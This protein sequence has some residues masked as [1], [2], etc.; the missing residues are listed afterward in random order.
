MFYKRIEPFLNRSEFISKFDTECVELPTKSVIN[1]LNQSAKSLLLARALEITCKNIIM[2][3]SDDKTAEEFT[4]DVDLL[5]GTER[6]FYLPDFEVLPYEERSPHYVI[7]AQRI[8]AL[9]RAVTGEPAVFNLSLRSFLR[10]IVHPDIFGEH[11]INLK[12]GEEY[13]PQL[14][15]SNLVGMGYENEYQ[16]SKVGDVARRGGIIDVFSPSTSKPVRI[17]FFGD[18]IESIRIFSISS[19]RSTGEELKSIVLLPSRE[20]SLHDIDTDEKM[21]E[22]IHKDGFYEGIESDVSLLLP[23]TGTFLDFFQQN[24]CLIF[25]DNFQYFNNYIREI[26]EETTSLYQKAALKNKKRSFVHP[27]ELFKNKRYINKI[28]RKYDHFYLSSG[29]QEIKNSLSSYEAPLL[30]QNNLHGKLED[31]EAE[32]DRRISENYRIIIQSDNSSQSKRMRDLLPQLEEQLDF[33]IGVFQKGFLLTD[34][35]IA[36]YTDHEIFS[37]YK[38]KRRQIKFSKDEVLVDYESLRPGDYIVHIDHGIGIY[39]G[40]K[41]LIVD[42]NTIECLKLNYAGNDSVYIPTYQLSMVSKYISQEGIAPSIHKLGGKRWEQSKSK[43][44]KQLELIAEDL[45]KLYAER[46]VKKGIAFDRDGLWQ[47]EMEDSFIYEDTPDQHRATN[48][49]KEDMEDSAPM[50]RLLCGDVGFGKTEVA[51]RAA[52]KAVLSGWQVA[53]LVPTTLLAEQHYLVFRERLAQYPVRITM[54]SRFRTHTE[55]KKDVVRLNEGEIDI[56]IGTHRLISKDV[57]FKRLGLLIIDEEHRFG[58]RHKEKLRKLKTNVDTLY[59]SATPIPRTMYMALSKLKELSLIRTSPKS[60]LPIRT[61]IVPYDKDIIK[62]AISRE[63][64]RGGQVFFVHNRIQTID[65][66]AAELKALLPNVRFAIGHGQ[67][68][69]KLLERITLDFADHQFDVL[70]STTIIESGI[71]IPN[72]NT[73]VINRADMFGLAQLYQIRGRVGRSSRRAYA[74]L[75]I[76]PRF[77]EEA[78]SR[79]ETLIEYESL[80]SGYQ[81]AMRDMELRGAGALLGTRQSGIINTIGF[82]YYNRLLDKAI[83]SVQENKPLEDKEQDDL[84]RVKRLQIESDFY[85]PDNYIEDEKERLNLYRKMLDLDSEDKFNLLE[86]EL[87]DR[88]GEIPQ[89]A[90]NAL[91]YYRLNMLIRIAGLESFALKKGKILVEFNNRKLPARDKIILMIN[92]IDLPVTLD[93]TGNMKITFDL[94]GGEDISQNKLYETALKI[95]RIIINTL[96]PAESDRGID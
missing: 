70:I 17:E 33:T 13:D 38:R 65:S 89:N 18:E 60:R 79:L 35:R 74:Y 58:V 82:N 30:P 48:E 24:N 22:R 66:I 4:D 1:N 71:D 69:E 47:K 23:K 40:L 43:A 92:E 6:S 29:H 32:L 95:V 16:V 73:I 5:I 78:R 51:I 42:G 77:T 80:G 57:S 45:V 83:K 94:K 19:Q 36:V 21:W 87:K 61:V 2:V 59:M 85:F 7:R 3:S 15:L 50:E 26:L 75:I 91:L 14:L 46:K 34:A 90:R 53:V 49:I 8:E 9:A 84:S 86:A 27:D 10:N 67:L 12:K 76:P 28:N 93:G 31:L 41:Q 96:L 52:F 63:V 55:L 25:W 88:F 37:R 44:R 62:D 68:P 54:F 56:A 81:I 72:V 39:G 20:F 11:V 64:D